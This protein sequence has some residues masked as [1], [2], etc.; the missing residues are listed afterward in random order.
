MR[1]LRAER[2]EEVRRELAVGTGP[3]VERPWRRS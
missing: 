3:E 1:L 2:D